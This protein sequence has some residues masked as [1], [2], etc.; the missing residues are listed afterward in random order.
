MVGKQVDNARLRRKAHERL[1]EA[2]DE[3][4]QQGYFG[5]AGRAFFVSW[6]LGDR[7]MDESY[8]LIRREIEALVAE[9]RKLAADGL[10]F[11]EAWTLV[12]QGIRTIV[13]VVETVSE[14]GEKKRELALLCVDRFAAAVLK[15]WDIPRIPNWIEGPVDRAI[16]T[17]LMAVAGGIIDSIIE[18]WNR[19]G[20]PD[21]ISLRG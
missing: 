17:A 10:T 1:D 2:L 14:S 6:T 21:L 5:T 13:K 4:L 18:S 11:S 16:H 19:G 3:A 8:D 7:A 9:G 12:R 20:W 15:A